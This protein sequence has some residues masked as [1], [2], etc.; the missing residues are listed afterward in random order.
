MAG[1]RYHK[2]LFVEKCPFSGAL[3]TGLLTKQM[4]VNHLSL[5]VMMDLSVIA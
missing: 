4:I 2:G 5:Y 3:S 1:M